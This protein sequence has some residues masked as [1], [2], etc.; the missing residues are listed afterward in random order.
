MTLSA[1][2]ENISHLNGANNGYPSERVFIANSSRIIT[3]LSSEFCKLAGFDSRKITGK[4]L[5]EA[6]EISTGSPFSSLFSWASDGTQ[7]PEMEIIFPVPD[8]SVQ[9][10]FSKHLRLGEDDRLTEIIICGKSITNQALGLESSLGFRL[11]ELLK[12]NPAS[13]YTFYL[14]DGVPHLNFVND[15]IVKSL[16]YSADQLLDNFSF[17]IEHVHPEDRPRLKKNF[18]ENYIAPKVGSVNET[19]YRFLDAWGNYRW[20]FNRQQIVAERDGGYDVSC[21]W[22]DITKQKEEQ[23]ALEN[24]SRLRQIVENLDM[25]FWLSSADRKQLLYI[26]ENLYHTF[27]IPVKQNPG[28]L[29]LHFLL[30]TVI[31]GDREKARNA[32]KNFRNGKSLGDEFRTITKENKI[33]WLRIESFPVYNDK[34]EIIRYAGIARNITQEKFNEQHLIEAREQ[35]QA[36]FEGSPQGIIAADIETQLFVFVNPEM[37]RLFGYTEEEFSNMTPVNLHRPEDLPKVMEQFIALAENRISIASV[38]PCLR[39]DGSIFYADINTRHVTLAGKKVMIGFFVDVTPREENRQKIIELN[40]RMLLANKAAHIGI[41]EWDIN[42]DKVYFDDTMH[43]I[44]GTS[45][46]TFQGSMENWMSFILQNGNSSESSRGSL[47]TGSSGSAS[48]FSI[49]NTDG[50]IRYI[51]AVGAVTPEESGKSGHIFGVHIDITDQKLAEQEKLLSEQRYSSLVNEFHFGVIIHGS[52]GELLYYNS[53][54]ES[55]IGMPLEKIKDFNPSEP[56]IVLKTGNGDK[57]EPENYPFN[58][59]IRTGKEIKNTTYELNNLITG[60][61]YWIRLHAYP[62]FDAGNALK[63]VVVTFVNITDLIE[64][65]QELQRSE[66]V[67]RRTQELA[68]VGGFEWSADTNT[69]YWTDEMYAIHDMT[70][71]EFPPGSPQHIEASLACYPPEELQKITSAMNA[72]LTDG[73]PYDLV[74]SFTTPA[75]NE[76]WI[77]AAATA[78]MKDGKISRITGHMMDVTIGRKSE[79]NLVKLSRAV[80]QSPVSVII[81]DPDGIVEFVNPRFTEVT[82]YSEEEILGR[83][84]AILEHEFFSK[85]IYNEIRETINTGKDWKGELLNRKKDGSLYWES[86]Y[87]SPVLNPEGDIINVISVGEDITERKKNIEELITAKVKAEEMSKLKSSFLANMSHELRTPLVAINGFAEIL[88]EETSG[89]LNKMAVGILRGGR[90]LSETLNLILDL[91]KI[92][93]GA[94]QLSP[95]K[96]DVC[97]ETREAAELFRAEA[98]K[99]GLRYEVFCPDEKL[100]LKVDPKVLR[101]AINNLINNAIKYTS[102]G[103]LEVRLI[104]KEPGA[105]I[106]TVKD[107]G[108]GIDQAHHESI[109]EEFR[110]V[111]EGHGRNFEGTGLGLSIVKKLIIAHGG[112]ITVE[113]EPGKGSTF[114]VTLPSH[115]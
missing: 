103:S 26:S 115:E 43:R 92:E 30:S 48:E 12:S 105:M 99:K 104:Y 69:M 7:Q 35:Y 10:S 45:P 78:A 8:R 14:K 84:P 44:Y 102:T 46:E 28:K 59:V 9:I 110:Q 5:A 58:L 37:T 87:I 36:V 114:T 53:E 24:H 75:G 3:W 94:M 68:K 74:M 23:D 86:T 49:R 77:R 2:S 80:L 56:M 57:I 97:A 60:K 96:L 81:T 55:L 11:I 18:Q 42:S 20:L 16:G 112:T 22:M 27:G 61:R 113:S 52:T 13:L 50:R 76:K 98:E 107:T 54:A 71:G 19:E 73:T 31:P 34:N 39:K 47:L 85:D 63:Q 17:W 111:S 65:E 6:A 93:S 100:F 29:S 88:A 89:E 33:I 51:R 109:F 66:A 67:L 64:T 62:Q 91:A 15:H 82:G 40:E 70:P 32:F 41:W 25:F 38:I 101:S 79:M 106:L 21:I 90:R 1:G 4:S 95:Q 83:K 72:I 108:I